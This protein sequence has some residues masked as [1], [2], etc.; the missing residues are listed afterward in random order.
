MH[1]VTMYVRYTTRHARC[2]SLCVRCAT[3]HI[4]CMPL[5]VRCTTRQLRCIHLYVRCTTRHT[6]CTPL[7]VRCTTRQTRYTPSISLL[8]RVYDPARHAYTVMRYVLNSLSHVNSLFH[9]QICMSDYRDRPI[10]M[11]NYLPLSRVDQ[12]SEPAVYTR[13]GYPLTDPG[14]E[15]TRAFAPA[16]RCMDPAVEAIK[17][18][19]EQ[20]LRLD[21]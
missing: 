13:R 16:S 7:Y 2:T 9:S 5:Y 14:R 10:V 4:R 11:P 6:L 8:S 19:A 20:I 21:D 12:G 15:K 17:T 1:D 3:R 18:G